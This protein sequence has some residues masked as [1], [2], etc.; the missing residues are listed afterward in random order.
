MAYF[1]PAHQLRPDKR[2]GL[3]PGGVERMKAMVL[4]A[5]R[6][7]RLRP[8]TDEPPK[9]LIPVAGEPLVAHHL[10][11]L[12]G[13]G[14]REVVMN[15]SWLAGRVREAL[16]DGGAWKLRIHYSQEPWPP[17]ET[18]GGIFAALPMLGDAPFLLVNSDVWT[19]VDF[20]DLALPTGMLAHLVLVPNPAHNPDGD[21]GLEDGRVGL[22]DGPRL[23]YG[24]IGVLDPGLFRDCHPGRFPLAPLLQGAAR[25]GRVSGERHDGEWLD[26]GT[27]E[28]LQALR[29]QL[30]ASR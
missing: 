18:G 23:T 14:V 8:L 20:A 22:G 19:D 26:V 24:G 1:A 15:V 17:L 11:A 28:R 2:P 27:P 10:R 16:G 12:A 5:G 3:V 30:A 6:G 13:A 21:F 29:E 25:A 4:A 9:P 7:E